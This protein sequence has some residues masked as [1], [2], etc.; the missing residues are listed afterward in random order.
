MGSGT[1]RSR[2]RPLRRRTRAAHKTTSVSI[3]S[4]RFKPDSVD[5]QAGDSVEWTNN[6]DS[7]HTVTAA[8]SSFD[9]GKLGTGKVYKHKFDTAGRFSYACDRHPREKG[10]VIVH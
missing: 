4:H 7:D 1:D 3:E 10:V 2:R 6:D 8:D 9:S 5:V